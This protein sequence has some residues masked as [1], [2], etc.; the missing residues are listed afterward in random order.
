[1]GLVKAELELINAVDLGKWRDGDIKEEAIRRITVEA[2]ADSGA[3]MMVIP[4]HVR[5][6]LGLHIIKEEEAEYASGEMAKVPIAGPIE[7]CFANRRAVGDA[8]V[9]GNEVLLGSLDMEAMDVI[10]HPKN[11]KLVVNPANPTFPKRIV[12]G[13]RR[14]RT[15]TD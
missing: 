14:P 10:I 2:L 6:Q 9:I 12:K 3:Y 7:I 1:M 5:L 15:E 8:M 11:Q 4:E 13:V